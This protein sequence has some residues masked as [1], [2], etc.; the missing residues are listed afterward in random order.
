MKETRLHK[1]A[2]RV[3]GNVWAAGSVRGREKAI[4]YDMGVGSSQC[5]CGRVLGSGEPEG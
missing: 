3:T 1:E 2:F 5:S 4:P